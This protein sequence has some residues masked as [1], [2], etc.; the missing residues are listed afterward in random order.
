MEKKTEQNHVSD[1]AFQSQKCEL[2]V[3]YVS[4]ILFLFINPKH[5][6]ISLLV[7]ECHLLVLSTLIFGDSEAVSQFLELA[8]NRIPKGTSREKDMGGCGETSALCAGPCG[9]SQGA[10]RPPYLRGARSL[11]QCVTA[12]KEAVTLKG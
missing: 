11:D 8:G 9:P 7:L 5:L 3:V 4:E 6:K 10:L 1:L 12:E 2:G